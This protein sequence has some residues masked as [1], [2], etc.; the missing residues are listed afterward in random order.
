[1]IS[2]SSGLLVLREE[3]VRKDDIYYGNFLNRMTVAR[4]RETGRAHLGHHP[5]S[6]ERIETRQSP[7]TRDLRESL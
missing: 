7:S 4:S 2:K 1:M 6:Q 5:F 3:K